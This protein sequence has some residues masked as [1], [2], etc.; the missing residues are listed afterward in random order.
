MNRSFKHSNIK[1]KLPFVGEVWHRP[2]A[3]D[4]NYYYIGEVTEV[5]I[6]EV[7]YSKWSYNKNFILGC[8]IILKP[9]ETDS[10][11]NL[12]DTFGP[13]YCTPFAKFWEKVQ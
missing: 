1:Y 12:K 10:D 8:Q 13:F 6:N 3:E 2:W 5:N 11:Y 4:P 9:H 7:N